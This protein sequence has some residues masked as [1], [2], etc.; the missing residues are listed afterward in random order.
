MFFNSFS[1]RASPPI[2]SLLN[3]SL[4]IPVLSI[5]TDRET[6]SPPSSSL[7]LTRKA[8]ICRGWHTLSHPLSVLSQTEFE[9]IKNTVSASLAL[10][11]Q[12]SRVALVTYG[13]TVSPFLSLS[14]VVPITG[15]RSN[16]FSLFSRIG[17]SPRTLEQRHFPKLCFQR[18]RPYP[19]GGQE[20]TWSWEASPGWPSLY[21]NFLDSFLFETVA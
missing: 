3:Y 10:I 19:W 11:P 2:P 21:L 20:A 13:T 18:E 12:Y 16:R 4:N 7:S 1:S 17:P 8:G 14:F 9:A 15:W 5:L 6:A